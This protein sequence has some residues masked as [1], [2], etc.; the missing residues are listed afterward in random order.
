M[1]FL[2][3]IVHEALKDDGNIRNQWKKFKIIAS[4]PIRKAGS[5]TENVKRVLFRRHYSAI[6]YGSL[7]TKLTVTGLKRWRSTTTNSYTDFKGVPRWTSASATFPR[8]EMD[9]IEMIFK[10]IPLSLNANNNFSGRDTE[11]HFT[12][13]MVLGSLGYTVGGL[14]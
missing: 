9:N 1:K 5:C 4:F 12:S 10:E 2:G 11:R 7:W 3:H 8:A 13:R 6:Y 14:Q